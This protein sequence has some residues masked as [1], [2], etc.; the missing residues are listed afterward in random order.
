VRWTAF[1]LGV[2]MVVDEEFGV[3][4]GNPAWI[5]DLPHH[6]PEFVQTS[7]HAALQHK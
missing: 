1:Q 7:T 3:I 4:S 6:L 2:D 5:Q